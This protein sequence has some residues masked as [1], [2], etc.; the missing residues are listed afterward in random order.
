[1]NDAVE[2]LFAGMS[3]PEEV[4]QQIEDAASLELD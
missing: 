3:T 2:G 1:V 4:A